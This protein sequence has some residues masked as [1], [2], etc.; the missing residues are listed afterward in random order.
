MKIYNEQE[1]RG[2]LEAVGVDPGAYQYL[3]PKAFFH[4]LKLKNI[5]ARAAL[6][7]KQEMLSK[8]G[9]AAI[10]RQALSGEGCGDVLLLGTTKQYRLLL[11]KLKIQ[12][13]GLKGL[14]AEIE[15]I[16]AAAEPKER[17]LRL[18]G[19][20]EL[21]LGQRPLIMGILNVTPDSF[22]DGGRYIDPG[23]AL[24]HA[25]QML[26]EGADIIDVGGASS[27]PGSEMADE[28]QELGRVL[29]VVEKL[30][31]ENCLV[32][33]DTFRGKVARACLERGVHIINDIG[34]LQMDDSLLPV[35]IEHQAPVVL[36]HNRMQ[37]K[38]NE[39][40]E[41]LISDI[42]I[43]LEE[44]IDQALQGGLTRDQIVVDPGI[45]FGKNAAQNRLIIKHLAEFRSLGYPVLL[46][47]SRKRF[48]GQTLDLEV[49][50][51]LEGSLAVAAVAVMNG[52]DIIRVHDVKAS[53]RIA[54][55]TWAVMR[56]N[57]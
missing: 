33:V 55:M 46:G 4:C 17:V 37:L 6:I 21:Q 51:R 40:Y 10:A 15:S 31:Q 39:P 32:S 24:E 9:E 43:E 52:A 41:D 45:G 8:G 44:S 26:E 57:G 19:G 18:A 23:R 34:R 56:E 38:Q 30:L 3:L 14:A 48:I 53:R 35:L 49:D 27:R 50:D 36:M 12:P 42:L 5:S 54:D 1:A 47:A 16:L 11:D 7:I 22:S 25:R 20:R 29:P 13:F 28:D 2:L